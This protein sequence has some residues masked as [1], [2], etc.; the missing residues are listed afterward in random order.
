VFSLSSADGV[1]RI[2]DAAI[3]VHQ[4]MDGPG[5]SQGIRITGVEDIPAHH[6]T[7]HVG[8]GV[9]TRDHLVEQGRGV[10]NRLSTQ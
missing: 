8:T 4:I 7:A 1:E 9:E 2:I 5:Y 10:A 3:L 6:G